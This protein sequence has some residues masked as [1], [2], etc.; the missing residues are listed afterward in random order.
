MAMAKWK[1]VFEFEVEEPTV[2]TAFFSALLKFDEFVTD[3]GLGMWDGQFPFKWHVEKIEE[4][5]GRE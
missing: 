3:L 2:S 4:R 5:D 1:V